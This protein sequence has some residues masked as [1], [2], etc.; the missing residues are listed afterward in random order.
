MIGRIFLSLLFLFEAYD[1][2][3]YFAETKQRMTE[4][5]VIWKQDFL[6]Y[7]SIFLL[8]FGGLLIL[9][10]YRAKLGAWM[11]LLYW[12]PLT[13]SVN[14]FW[15]YPSEERRF[16]LLLFMRNL[17]IIGG[18]LLIVANGSRRF[19]IKKIFATTRVP[20]QEWWN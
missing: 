10:G 14:D 15:N 1:S 20:T 11:L 5:G 3:W 13:L 4:F 2:I 18:L 6:L 8:I 16:Q 9:S 7:L 12:I 19:A 17:A